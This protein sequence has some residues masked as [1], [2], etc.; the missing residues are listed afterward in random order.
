[1]RTMQ[2]AVAIMGAALV[3][4]T[5]VAAPGTAT[6]AA[7]PLPGKTLVV[8]VTGTSGAPARI[9]VAGPKGFTK[10]LRLDGRVRLKGLSPGRYTLRAKP[11]GKAEA[12]EPI[13][14]VRVRKGEGAH[15]RFTYR[16]PAAD[17]EA[18]APVTELRTV[19]VT[20]TTVSLA[21][22]N[23]PDGTF[24]LVLVTRKGGTGN[25][26]GD[27]DYKPDATGLRDTGLAPDTEYTYTVSTKDEAG[28]ISPGVSIT[29][30]T[31]VA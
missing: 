21:W 11:V 26:P 8:R 22:N 20:A 3:G 28:N 13:Q 24:L 19:E 2:R 27:L 29:V 6:L 5:M 7:K 14:S 25:E 4:L 23:P 18:P 1:M 31:L 17:T 30:R 12:T 15:V 16:V 10:I 9:K